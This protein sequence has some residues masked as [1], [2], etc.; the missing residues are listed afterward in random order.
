MAWIA[1]TT[2]RGPKLQSAS[3]LRLPTATLRRDPSLPRLRRRVGVGA[4]L[5]LYLAA[6][7]DLVLIRHAVLADALSRVAGS[8]FALYSR[9]PHLAA[10]GFVRMPLP[11][12]LTLPLLPFKAIFPALTQA[13]FAA[14]IVSAVVMAGAA[15]HADGNLVC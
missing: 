14:N 13:G 12:L 9:A 7:V 8:Y 10:S 2:R 5:A 11:S 15:L 6:A 4:C 3:L 1:A